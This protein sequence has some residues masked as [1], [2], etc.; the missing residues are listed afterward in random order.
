MAAQIEGVEVTGGVFGGSNPGGGW[1]GHA[2]L[3]GSGGI[4]CAR[5]GFVMA[6]GGNEVAVTRMDVE[7]IKAWVTGERIG[8]FTAHAAADLTKDFID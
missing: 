7:F 3:I 6:G 5:L 8:H 1:V 4:V 2:G